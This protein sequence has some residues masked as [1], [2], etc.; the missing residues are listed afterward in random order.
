MADFRG[1]GR[2]NSA[3]RPVQPSLAE[4]SNPTHSADLRP[5]PQAGSPLNQPENIVL[6]PAG[7][8]LLQVAKPQVARRAGRSGVVVQAA[9]RNLWAPGELV[10]ARSSVPCTLSSLRYR[11]NRVSIVTAP[12][13]ARKHTAC[14]SAV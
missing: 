14:P 12:R 13:P 4:P 5:P 2:Q 1:A 9:A 8:P 6:S 3:R 7:S 10:A 11:P